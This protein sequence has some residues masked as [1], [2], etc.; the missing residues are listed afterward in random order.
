MSGN[1]RT[2]RSRIVAGLLS[3]LRPLY[4]VTR[5]HG[6]EQEPMIRKAYCVGFASLLLAL[7]FLTGCSSTTATPPATA[8]T[9]VTAN[10]PYTQDSTINTASTNPTVPFASPFSATVTTS[11]TP[12]AIGTPVAGVVVTFTAPLSGAGGGFGSP[13]GPNF[14]TATTGANGIATSPT[15]YANG[16]VGTYLVIA[17]A[18]TTQSTALFNLSNTSVPAPITVAGGSPQSTTIGLEFGTALSATV[19]DSTG[20]AVSGLPVTF[21]VNP[22]AGAGAT[23]IDTDSATTTATTNS[24]GVATAAL[25]TANTTVGSYTA[26]ASVGGDAATATFILSNTIAPVAITPVSGSTPQ[27]AAVSTDFANPLAVV[28]TGAA[29]APVVG[30]V[31]TFTAP[32]QPA[33]PAAPVPSGTFADSGTITT[34]AVTDATGT[35][36]PAT[37]TANA[38]ASPVG[39]PVVTYNVTATVVI[40]NGSTLTTNFVLTNQ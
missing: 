36:T 38:V 37:F 16:T 22:V 18:E 26:T 24:S 15:F 7:A 11:T 23:F 8:I 21:T 17:S 35:A 29:G 19:K 2:K 13:S 32:A 28:V 12:G 6:R 14:A 5:Q 39:P 30:A 1:R 40:T 9:T 31:V 4:D 3:S 27:S 10:S 25:L 33:S 34:T 20:A